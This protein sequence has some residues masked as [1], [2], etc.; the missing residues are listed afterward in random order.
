[1]M[2]AVQFGSLNAFPSQFADIVGGRL[3]YLPPNWTNNISLQA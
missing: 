1:M 3:V 2:A